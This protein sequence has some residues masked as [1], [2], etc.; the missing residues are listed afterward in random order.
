MKGKILCAI[1]VLLTLSSC[2]STQYVPLDYSD[3]KSPKIEVFLTCIQKPSREFEI[4]AYIE[5]SGSVFASQKQLL[6][7]LK[8]KAEKLGG[9][10]VTEVNFF[11]IPWVLSSLPSVKGVVIKYKK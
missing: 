4:V 7:G 11:Y 9:D 1:I 5:T 2:T 6:R 10:A 3:K 8:K